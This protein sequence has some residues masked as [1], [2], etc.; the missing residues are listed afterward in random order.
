MDQKNTGDKIPKVGQTAIVRNRPAV[1]REVTESRT[2]GL[3]TVHGVLVEYIDGFTSPSEDF[4]LWE[5][6]LRNELLSAASMPGLLSINQVDL[7]GVFHSFINSYRWS[8]INRIDHLAD[9]S[10][11]Q[12]IVSPWLSAIQVED[13]QLYPVIK[14]LNMP[15]ITLLLADDV[16][17]GK[18]I[19]AGLILNELTSRGRLR[20]VM[21]L[22][23][24]SL[25]IQWR[26]EM[27]EKFSLEFT[28]INREKTLELQKEFGIDTNPWAFYPRVITSFDYLRQ[29]DV[30]ESFDS[31]IGSMTQQ[32]SNSSLWEMLVIDEVHNIAPKHLAD[33]T[34]RL[35]MVKQ[36][37][38]NFEHRLFLSATPHN[39]FTESFTGLLEVLN[40]LV[41][42]QKFKLSDS[43]PLFISEHVIRRMKSDFKK[44][45]L[46]KRF[47]DRK[48]EKIKEYQTLSYH[49]K[50]LFEALR[51][52]RDRALELAEEESAPKKYI[53]QFLIILLTKRLLSGTFSFATTWWNHFE[54]LQEKEVNDQEVDYAIQRATEDI[55][56]DDEKNLRQQEVVKKIGTW[57][58]RNAHLLKEEINLIN[59]ILNLMG[60]SK[61]FISKPLTGEISK[62]TDTK[63]NALHK[64]IQSNLLVNGKPRDDERV[65]IFTEYKHTLEYLKKRFELAGLRAPVLQTLTGGSTQKEREELKIHFNDPGSPL[66]I[67]LVTDVA[68]EGINLQHNCRF[69]IHYEIPWNPMRLEQRNGRVDR[70][71]QAR[72]VTIFHFVADDEEDYQFLERVVLKVEQI[73]ED[74]GAVSDV[75]DESITSHFTGN[76]QS[77]GLPDTSGI[78]E[79]SKEKEV[80][81]ASDKGSDEGYKNSLQQL[82]TTE[83]NMNLN[84]DSLASLLKNAFRM[85]GG[86]LVADA[87]EK[88]FFRIASIP[89]KW[90]KDVNKYLQTEKGALPKLVFDS[91][92]FKETRN[93]RMIYRNFPDTKLIR[94]AHPL[95]KKAVNLFKRSLWSAPGSTSENLSRISIVKTALPSG[96]N[97]VIGFYLLIDCYNE[98]RERIHQEVIE[99]KYLVTGNRI[100]PLYEDLA[101]AINLKEHFPLTPEEFSRIMPD[102]KSN[103]FKIEEHLKSETQL[104]K[105]ETQKRFSDFLKSRLASEIENTRKRYDQRIKEL[106]RRRDTEYIERMRKQLVFEKQSLQQQTLFRESENE[107]L[108]KIE[109]I[110]KNLEQ[111]MTSKTGYISAVIENEKKKLLETIIPKR[112]SIGWLEVQPLGIEVIIDTKI[113]GA[114]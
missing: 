102:I 31:T 72:D 13:Y 90:A 53:V 109:E 69:V 3:E 71:G 96:F 17:L 15:R 7:P 87:E 29:K 75:L 94:L 60:L 98:L 84:P 97:E 67:L 33:E 56:D 42:E 37:I 58:S 88:G 1:I 55:T 80:E 81:S 52:Y 26:D 103:W 89:P 48:I 50:N 23:P 70:F 112:F 74:L 113:A 111:L 99:K 34:D 86:S 20:R 45:A 95:M 25:Q 73:R 106:A 49:E 57:F 46:I 6:E 51:F 82:R 9:R 76:K 11:A 108:K 43:D 63:W 100:E 8:S 22:C 79:K 12:H 65:I 68:S 38:P 62:I 10:K 28:I 24:A 110:E 105:S 104:L 107:R 14:A 16:G 27:M 61:D 19:E 32:G 35:K 41:F 54:G 40:P 59:S 77:E 78:I 91:G 47:C 36:I 92:F 66:S 44:D 83:L 114:L 39:G 2:T 64:W 5:L 4:V 30:L 21:I 101:R 18:T 85:E 93:G